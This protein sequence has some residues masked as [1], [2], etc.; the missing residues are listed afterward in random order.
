MFQVDKINLKIIDVGGQ[1]RERRKWIHSFEVET[2]FLLSYDADYRSMRSR[3]LLTT[4]FQ[5]VTSVIFLASLSEYDMF[6]QECKT[7]NRT[8]ES[9][10][11]RKV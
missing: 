9:L 8:E 3:K 2:K 7:K 5:G 1:R 6:L 11:V 10:Q 4:Y